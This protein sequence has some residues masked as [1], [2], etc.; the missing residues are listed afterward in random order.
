MFAFS[1]IDGVNRDSERSAPTDFKR[2]MSC[3]CYLYIF[4]LLDAHVNI[5]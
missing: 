5:F 2:F 1:V 4:V 3:L